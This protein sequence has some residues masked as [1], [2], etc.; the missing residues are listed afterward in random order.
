[1]KETI[2]EGRGS[3]STLSN[4]LPSTLRTWAEEL[5]HVFRCGDG[6]NLRIVPV[7]PDD[8]RGNGIFLGSAGGVV[9][10]GRH[11]LPSEGVW[12]DATSEKEEQIFPVSSE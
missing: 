10:L 9:V 12:M 3:S 2:G 1:V 11:Y 7:V 5:A 6:R 8:E 4:L